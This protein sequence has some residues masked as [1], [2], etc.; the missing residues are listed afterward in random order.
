MF[1]RIVEDQDI[2]TTK[3]QVAQKATE[4]SI[5]G[6][7]KRDRNGIGWIRQKTQITDL[8]YRIISLKWQRA[9]H[10]ASNNILH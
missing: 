2:M 6:I 7:T 3:L 1:N 8:F 9:G 5:Q 10:I 4:R